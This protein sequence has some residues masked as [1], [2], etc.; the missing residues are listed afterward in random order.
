MET[1]LGQ[2]S[3]KGPI[4]VWSMCPLFGGV[5][6]AQIV[7]V[8]Y[9]G[10]YYNVIGRGFLVHFRNHSVKSNN[11]TRQSPTPYFSCSLHLTLMY[12][13]PRVAIGGIRFVVWNLVRHQSIRLKMSSAVKL[14][15]RVCTTYFVV[16]RTK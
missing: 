10:I 4:K 12:H 16:R 8:F 5:G 6:V 1:S 15:I 13:G 7:L 14:V 9:V 11:P 3:A 2:Y